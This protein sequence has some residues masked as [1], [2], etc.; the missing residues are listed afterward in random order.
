VSMGLKEMM[1]KLHFFTIAKGHQRCMQW[2]LGNSRGFQSN[3]QRRRSEPSSLQ[4]S[5]DGSF[6]A[7]HR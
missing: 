6:Q 5:D 1:R 4:S 3:L 2:T 7:G